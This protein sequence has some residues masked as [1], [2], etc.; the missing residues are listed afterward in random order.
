MQYSERNTGHFE[1][2]A[3]EASR[4]KIYPVTLRHT[5]TEGC[6]SWSMSTVRTICA[7]LGLIPAACPPVH[8]VLRTHVLVPLPAGRPALFVDEMSVVDDV[9]EYPSLRVLMRGRERD[10]CVPPPLLLPSSDLMKVVS[11]T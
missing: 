11:D 5:I 10:G 6:I 2:R 8:G 7:P 4:R 9:S 3:S 1:D